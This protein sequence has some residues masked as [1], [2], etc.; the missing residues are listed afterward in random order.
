MH[1]NYVRDENFNILTAQR[2]KGILTFTV[3]TKEP[4]S[5]GDT[6]NYIY[7][8]NKQCVVDKIVERRD[9]K[10]YPKGNGMWYKVECSGINT[11]D[12]KK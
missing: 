10:A 6:I 2:N 9:A 3:E 1:H 12:I 7:G 8:E 4:L 5:V 11:A